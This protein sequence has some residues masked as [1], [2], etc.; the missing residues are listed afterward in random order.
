MV[1]TK[2]LIDIPQDIRQALAD[3]PSVLA[4]FE[5]LPGSHRREYL[6]WIAA[7]VN[8]RQRSERIQRLLL[9]MG[10]YR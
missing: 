10:L 2:T 6:D 7:S 8:A 1:T 5:Q 9:M 4:K 3:D